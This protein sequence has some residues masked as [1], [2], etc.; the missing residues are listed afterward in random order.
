MTM[1]LDKETHIN[2][3]SCSLKSQSP[4]TEYA[5]LRTDAEIVGTNMS[6]IAKY[7]DRDN[8]DDD[9]GGGGGVS[10]SVNRRCTWS[11]VYDEVV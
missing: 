10:R 11:Y 1:S 9:V 7:Q 3:G 2:Q 5:S 4:T 8:D 6:S